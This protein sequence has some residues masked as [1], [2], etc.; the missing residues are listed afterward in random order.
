MY[1]MLH[2]K[3][4]RKSQKGF[5]LIEVL[6]ATALL[7][8]LGVAILGALGSASKI[9]ISTDSSENAKDLAV[10]QMELIKSAAYNSTYNV[11]SS[12]LFTAASGY[13]ANIT[14]QAL[15]PDSSLQKV[16]ISV[17]QAGKGV[18]TLSDYRT[19]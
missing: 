7:A 18:Y 16:T 19:R 12:S 5:S 17:F 14:V 13:S 3:M 9:L 11:D 1:F 15:K 8:I 6:I 10:A 2:L 4:K